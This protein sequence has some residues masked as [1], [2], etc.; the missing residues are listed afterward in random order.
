MLLT[1][2]DLH[3]YV[4]KKK[5]LVK[6]LPEPKDWFGKDSSI[7][8]CS[9]DL[10]IG[11]ISIPAKKDTGKIK[12][13][14]GDDVV[15]AAG[16]TAVVTTLE[17]LELPKDVAGVG[18]SPSRVSIRGL[19][20]LNPGHVDPGY[21]GP[22]HLTVI[23]MGR[24]EFTLQPGAMIATL[25]FIKLDK[26]VQAAWGD[27]TN[28]PGGA[29]DDQKVNKLSNDFLNIERRATSI[30]RKA[31]AKAVLWSALIAGAVAIGSQFVPYYLGGINEA[32]RND[33]VMDVRINE[34][35][36]RV[37]QLE[38]NQ[39]KPPSSGGQTSSDRAT[40]SKK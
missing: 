39:A 33:A 8:P 6:N 17:T 23:N 7:Q 11:T 20:V 25:V 13:S 19:L 32:K 37:T 26:A 3:D 9:I 12:V 22:L 38:A 27:R 36:R 30:A 14:Q 21:A 16:R 24:D 40:G 31:V 2:V 35:N 4:T 10:H 29:L 18:F 15:L 28:P 1:D 34:L 5:T